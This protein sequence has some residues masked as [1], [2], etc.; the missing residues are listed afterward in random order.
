VTGPAHAPTDYPVAYRVRMARRVY[1]HI[2]TMKSGTTY[3]QEFCTR[4]RDALLEAGLLW[5]AS[6]MN[7]R[8][9]DDL[10]GTWRP[11]P[12]V[13]GAWGR[14]ASKIEA[15]DGAALI[16]NELLSPIFPPKMEQVLQALA[17]A[18]VRVII[19]AR[20]LGRVLP[21]HWQEGTR[22]RQTASWQEFFAAVKGEEGSDEQLNNGFW[23]KHGVGAMVNRWAKQVGLDN[24][25]VVTVP[26][27]GSPSTLLVERFFAAMD[28]SLAE[29]EQPR[30]LH[31]SLG[32]HSVEVMR[33]LNER[34]ADFEWLR[35][36]WG[37]KQSLSR[38]VLTPRSSREPSIRLTRHEREW[39]SKRAEIMISAIEDTGVSVIGDLGDLR[40]APASKSDP[41]RHAEASEA[42]VLDAALDGLVG[43]GGILADTRIAYDRLL[44]AIDGYLPPPTDAERRQFDITDDGAAEPPPGLPRDSRFIAW[45][46]AQLQP[47]RGHRAPELRTAEDDEDDDAPDAHAGDD[48]S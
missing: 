30:Y 2:G 25:T 3:I 8:A 13:E 28:L 24:V 46:L 48:I 29:F 15:H 37:F 42:E 40:P 16:S 4:N 32:V 22:N 6:V 21:S 9:V 38:H 17:P 44:R 26:P 23:R 41:D 36:Q 33:R 5:T 20:D 47:L 27:S 12:G 14:L 31:E 18:E 45:R 35:Y 34:N 10:L 39:V 19:T 43:L 7:F 1:L 11:R